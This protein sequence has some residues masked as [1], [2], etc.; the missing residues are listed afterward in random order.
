MPQLRA[1]GPSEVC[2][3]DITYLTTTVRSVWRYFYL[4]IDACSRRVVALDVLSEKTQPL[5]PTWRLKLTQEVQ[6]GQSAAFGSARQQ[7][8]KHTCR[9]AGKP[10]VGTGR[11]QVFFETSSVQ[12][13]PLF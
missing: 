1:A 12:R 3:W 5:Q 8:E 13:Q 10:A 7:R 11:A 9:Q 6:Q 4:L 2:S